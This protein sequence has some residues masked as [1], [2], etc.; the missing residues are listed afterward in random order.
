MSQSPSSPGSSR[1][2]YSRAPATLRWLSLAT[3]LT[4]YGLIV[5]GGVVRATGSGDACPDW[6]RCHG[7]LIPPFETD[8]LIEFSH[9]LM[10]SLVGFLTVG[11]AALTWRTQRDRPLLLGACAVALV[12]L[13]VQVVLG[14][15]TV[16]SDLSAG[17]VM[18]HLAVASLFIAVLIGITLALW[19]VPADAA[20]AV[21]FRNL[22]SLAA[23][24]TILLLL[25]GSY[26]SGSGAGLAFRDW[27]L[28]DGQ[29]IPDGGRLAMIHALHRF[30]AGAVGI[31]LIYLAFAARRSAREH[32]TIVVATTAGAALVVV[33]AF[34]G[35]ANI[36]TE[37][38]PAARGAH[39]ALAE[40]VWAVTAAAAILA[41]AGSQRPSEAPAG[42]G[43]APATSPLPA[44]GSR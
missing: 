32:P 23:V 6:P 10:A 1:K 25:T 44:G 33:Q 40:A 42:A 41:W 37:L 29:L 13:V 26:V 9:R 17:M 8:V 30:V 34:V 2:T 43:R 20:V 22:A 28:F 31:L 39:L 15:I 38:Q 4:T 3:V 19:D 24:S 16:L 14:G 27:P 18:A 11:V 7:Q 36:W 12:L 35:A 21:P 5:L